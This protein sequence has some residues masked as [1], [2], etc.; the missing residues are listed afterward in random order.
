MS[1]PRKLTRLRA[2]E[3]CLAILSHEDMSRNDAIAVLHSLQSFRM[4]CMP[5]LNPPAPKK[6]ASP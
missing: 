5:E 4:S 6:R 1:K 2:F 3:D